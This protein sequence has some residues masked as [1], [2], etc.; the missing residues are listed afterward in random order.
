[1]AAVAF[2]P[3][4]E[5]LASG[6]CHPFPLP[7]YNDLL[8]V[9]DVNNGKIVATPAWTAS[10]IFCVAFS[11]DG[12]FLASTETQE[13]KLWDAAS[14]KNVATLG[15]L[16]VSGGRSQAF[17]ISPD[18]KTIAAIAGDGK[19]GGNTRVMLWCTSTR[20]RYRTLNAD[21]N[22][23]SLVFAPD[24]NRVAATVRGSVEILGLATGKIAD[25]FRDPRGCCL[26]CIAIAANGKTL[27]AGG[28]TTID[29]WSTETHLNHHIER[30][31]GRDD[32]R[33]YHVR[34]VAFSPDGK[35]LAS[36]GTDGSVKLWSVKTGAN[37]LTAHEPGTSCLVFSP[38]GKAIALGSTNGTISLWNVMRGK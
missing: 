37:L 20:T 19:V 18:G 29:L 27:A 1:V 8:N 23:G 38:D 24:G 31:H 26:D 34:S 16:N 30:A 21:G 36:A 28:E 9:W 15:P 13:I 3:D 6:R 12:R 10:C 25:S 4:G 5:K 11:P 32:G 35:T 22:V 14:W 33:G 2:S 17:A 7:A